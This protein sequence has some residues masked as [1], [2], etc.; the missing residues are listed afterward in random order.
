MW[1]GIVLGLAIVALLVRAGWLDHEA[2]KMGK[3]YVAVKQGRFRRVRF[4]LVDK[5][6]DPEAKRLQKVQKAM[7]EREADKR[8]AMQGP[9]N[10]GYL[11]PGKKRR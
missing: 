1:L 9:R 2:A 6:T 11:F 10:E 3:R 5:L 8:D 7:A 4:S